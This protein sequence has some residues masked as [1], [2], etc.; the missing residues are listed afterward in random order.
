MSVYM[1]A[2]LSFITFN[3]INIFYIIIGIIITI[4]IFINNIYS[5]SRSTIIILA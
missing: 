3:I 5:I 1:Y 2:L 4:T